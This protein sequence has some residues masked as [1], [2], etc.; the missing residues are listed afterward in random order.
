MSMGFTRRDLLPLAAVGMAG[1]GLALMLR[2]RAP[3]GRDVAGNAVA[4]AV[5]RDGDFPHEGPDD[6]D[7]VMA[8]FTDYQCPACRRVAPELAAAVRDDG[9]V[10]LI[11]RDWP[12]F[13]AVSDFAARVALAA[14]RQGLYPT[15]HQRLMRQSLPLDR[16][17]IERAVRDAG[18]DWLRIE[19][20]MATDSAAFAAL[21]GRTQRDAF[22]LGLAGTPAFLIDE[23]L[24]VGAIGRAAFERVFAA[25]RESR[26]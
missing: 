17:G 23:R 7:I 16:A 6:A 26:E 5:L 21:I 8:L 3:A 2:G 14:D 20:D 19:Q 22:A 4:A 24:V 9:R 18:G 1:L 12:I 13:G 10:R 15:V 25:V 11:Y